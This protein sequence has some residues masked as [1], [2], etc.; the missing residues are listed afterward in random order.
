MAPCKHGYADEPRENRDLA[1]LIGTGSPRC[2]KKCKGDVSYLDDQ[3]TQILAGICVRLTMET[4]KMV[5]DPSAPSLLTP[6]VFSSTDLSRFIDPRVY[7]RPLRELL[8]LIF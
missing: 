5:F 3:I 2:Q 7:S 1:F 8:S 6:F 4:V